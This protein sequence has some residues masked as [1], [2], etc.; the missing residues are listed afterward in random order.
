MIGRVWCANVAAK[1]TAATMTR[2]LVEFGDNNGN[3][4]MRNRQ[5]AAQA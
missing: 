3:G 5:W 2:R 4:A 1:A